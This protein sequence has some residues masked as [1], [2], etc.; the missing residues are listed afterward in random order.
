MF[1]VCFLPFINF[2]PS[3]LG[4]N[5]CLLLGDNAC[6]FISATMQARLDMEITAI[7]E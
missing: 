5:A 7:Y 1:N 3:L 4:D 6:L 2:S